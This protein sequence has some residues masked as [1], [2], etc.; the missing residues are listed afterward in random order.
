MDPTGRSGR[1]C[2]HPT[3]AEERRTRNAH[4]DNFIES[5]RGEG[6][7]WRA[8]WHLR[9]MLDAEHL[10]HSVEGPLKGDEE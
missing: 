8:V 5:S 1:I 9:S 10:R 3:G 2:A 6:P 4:Y 7:F